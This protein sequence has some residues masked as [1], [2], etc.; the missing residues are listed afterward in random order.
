LLDTSPGSCPVELVLALPDGS[1]A[2]LAL[3]GTRVTPDDHVLAGLERMFG[4]TVA[5]LR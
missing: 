4:E 1:E 3:D 2:V 5:E